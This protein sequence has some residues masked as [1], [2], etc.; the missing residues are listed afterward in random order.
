MYLVVI[1][2]M[3]TKTPLLTFC[4]TLGFSLAYLWVYLFKKKQYKKIGLSLGVVVIG[5]ASLL[6]ILPKTN[7]YKNIETHLDFL[8][9]HSLHEVFEKEEYIDHFIFSQRLTFFHDRALT[10]KESNLYQKLFGIGYL[11]NGNED[12]QIEMDYF[13]IY[14]NYGLFG[15]LIYFIT[16]LNV[17][18]KVLEKKGKK[19]FERYMT[20]VSVLLMFFLAFFTGHIFTTPAVSFICILLILSLKEHKK[21]Q[22]LIIEKEPKEYLKELEEDYHLTRWIKKDNILSYLWFK[23]LYFQS[24]DITIFQKEDKEYEKVASNKSIIVVERKKKNETNKKYVTKTE[25]LKNTDFYLKT[26]E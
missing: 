3:G 26:S 19:S 11:K 16:V 13:D 7:F 15:F 20:E 22:I 9:I 14:Y 12:K 2:M 24:Q 10:Y 8:G 6:L 23:I 18:Y 21:K 25:F 1:L 4:I 17:L 5:I